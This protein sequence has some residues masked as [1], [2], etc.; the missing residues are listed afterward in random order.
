MGQP[1]VNEGGVVNAASGISPKF[2]NGA[3]AQGSL[4]V[5]YGQTVGPAGLVASPLPWPT[6]LGGTSIK[7]TSG[8]VSADCPIYYTS[9]SQVAAVMPSN[10]PV[11]NATLTLTYNGTTSIGRTV[12][13]VASSFGIYAINLRGTGPGS[14]TNFESPD[15]SPLVNTAL[16]AAR[17]GQTLSLY[18]TGLGA[19]PAGSNDGAPV[20]TAIT[21][22]QPNVEVFVGGKRADLAYAGRAP[23]FASL[24]QINFVVPAGVDGCAVPV[25]IK[26]GNVIS[27]YTTIAVAASGGICQDAL[28]LS[29]AQLKKIAD[30]GSVKRASIALVRVDLEISIPILGSQSYKTDTGTAGFNEITASSIDR[31]GQLNVAGVSSVGTCFV[32]FDSVDKLIPSDPVATTGLDAGAVIN[33]AGSKGAKT[34]K[35]T[36]KGSYFETLATGSLSLPFPIPGVPT[37]GDP[38][39]YLLAGNYTVNNGAGGTDVGVFNT[40]FELPANVTWSNKGAIT[41][42]N[43]ANGQT[44]NW[45][46]GD[47][48]SYV[49][50]YGYS[51]SEISNKGQTGFFSCLERAGAGTFT[52]P[53]SI[54]LALPA[55]PAGSLEGFVPT[56]VLAIGRVSA[57]KEFTA[58]GLD[59]GIIVSTVQLAKTVQYQ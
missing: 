30:G 7:V 40:S 19:L 50:I 34:L 48:N 42:I 59:S 47:A 9:A 52:I 51:I 28:G 31:G 17:P 1:L 36:S 20:P 33:I 24:D 49:Q 5:L 53:A 38:E 43:R 10:V 21:I 37:G 13:V 27:N 8:S 4:F 18:G 45:T 29:S 11:G 22:N 32:Y 23:F 46:G 12:R 44:V 14:I 26:I 35:L 16:K 6:S 3:I 41:T 58:P 15:A 57:P 2:P 39:G 25:G 55:T 54:L 56:A